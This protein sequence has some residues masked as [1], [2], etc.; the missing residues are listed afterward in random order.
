M[1]FVATGFAVERFVFLHLFSMAPE[2]LMDRSECLKFTCFY[3]HL[4]LSSICQ[5]RI[6]MN[7]RR[8]QQSR[9]L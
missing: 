8:E 6:P 2:V 3:M 7:G 4:S 1:Q 9:T 5:A